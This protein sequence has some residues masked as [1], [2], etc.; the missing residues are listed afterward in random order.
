MLIPR[1]HF[2]KILTPFLG[3]IYIATLIFT[4]NII[5][6]VKIDFSLRL[7]HRASLYKDIHHSRCLSG[8]HSTQPDMYKGSARVSLTE[9]SFQVILPDPHSS[10]PALAASIDKIMLYKDYLKME[11]YKDSHMKSP[12]KSYMKDTYNVPGSISHSKRLLKHKPDIKFDNPHRRR[13]SRWSLL[14][15]LT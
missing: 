9:G 8:Q 13:T 7:N 10:V 14:P 15:S 2:L 4:R 3:S 5:I 6:S 12:I 1:T 11:E